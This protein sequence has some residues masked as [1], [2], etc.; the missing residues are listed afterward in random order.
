MA[1]RTTTPS[2]AAQRGWGRAAAPRDHRIQPP[3]RASA[4]RAGGGGE[5]TTGVADATGYPHKLQRGRKRARLRR[6]RPHNRDQFTMAAATILTGRLYVAA[7]ADATADAGK[8]NWVLKVAP[9]GGRGALTERGGGVAAAVAVAAGAVAPP[10]AADPPTE[11]PK[12]EVPHPGNAIPRRV[13]PTLQPKRGQ[14]RRQ[15]HHRDPAPAA[16][17]RHRH[18]R[19]GGRIVGGWR[20]GEV[21]PKSKKPNWRLSP[22][23]GGVKVRGG[24]CAAHPRHGPRLTSRGRRRRGG[25]AAPPVTDD[26]PAE[27]PKTQVPPP[28]GTVSHQC[29]HPSSPKSGQERGRSTSSTLSHAPAHVT[30]AGCNGAEASVSGGRGR[31]LQKAKSRTGGSPPRARGFEVW[32]GCR[33]AH[34]RCRPHP[35]LRGRRRR[36]GA[37]PPRVTADPPTEAPRTQVPHPDGAMPR[38]VAHPASQKEAK[39]RGRSTPKTPR[40]APA[41][42]AATGGNAAESLVGGGRGR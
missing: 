30:A 40:H 4:V 27:A 8:V 18:L 24:G 14:K 17:D 10:V 31:Q 42:F 6:R 22:R 16:C 35:M 37:A 36:R 15:E 33:A 1:A 2:S 41:P 13:A 5:G 26:P 7:A 11:A 19:P 32:G 20:R 38:R 21:A 9:A 12:K 28:D 39:K 29:T 23:A 3:P 25:A 34:P